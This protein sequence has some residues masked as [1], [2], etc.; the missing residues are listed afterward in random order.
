METLH[1][2]IYLKLRD[3]I[4]GGTFV[5]GEMLP[6]ENTLGKQ[7]QTARVTVRK[8][9]IRLADEG[10][11]YAVPSKGYFVNQKRRNLYAWSYD[12]KNLF[13]MNITSGKLIS[14]DLILPNVDISYNLR[15]PG[16]RYVVAIKRL[17]YSGETCVAYEENFFPY[18]SG[19]VID[20][21]TLQS[22]VLT[23]ILDQNT[24]LYD[25]SKKITCDVTDTYPTEISALDLSENVPVCRIE[26][27]IND[28]EDEPLAWSRRY[29]AITSLK[30]Y[31]ELSM[32]SLRR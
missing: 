18:F 5:V 28:D 12:E 29:F 23:D 3:A 7:F 26:T 9:L 10:Y 27:F 24:A 8:A 20:E 13:K 32:E 30:M 31:C 14:V 2:Q 17:F 15:V 16:D 11:I 25:I 6:S 1:N 19:M 4:E 21:N 22:A